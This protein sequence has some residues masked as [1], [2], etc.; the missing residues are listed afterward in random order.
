[1]YESLLDET[2]LSMEDLIEVV[3]DVDR[4]DGSSAWHSSLNMKVWQ[5]THSQYIPRNRETPS[6]WCTVLSV[7]MEFPDVPRE[8][9]PIPR[10]PHP[11]PR[12]A[13]PPGVSRRVRSKSGALM[14]LAR[15]RIKDAPLERCAFAYLR[16][17]TC[18]GSTDIEALLGCAGF[19]G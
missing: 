18:K 19:S 17:L 4:W 7:P 10:P 5:D 6:H 11:K 15:H 3:S 16:V 8:P 2:W 1:M 14:E 13:K 12:R 9:K